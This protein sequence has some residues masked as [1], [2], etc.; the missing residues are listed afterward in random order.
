MLKSLLAVVPLFAVLATVHAVH[1]AADNKA[2]PAAGPLQFTMKDIDGK[3]VDLAQ[4]KGKV[5]MIVNVASK[6]GNTPQYKQL[7]EAYK[8]YGDK[9]F[10]ILGFPANE[11]RQQEPGTNEEIKKFCTSKYNVDFPM[12][13]K[14]VVK[15]DGQAPLYQYL[16]SKQT[17][18]K[19]AGDI[20]WNFEK[21]LVGRDGQVAARFTPKTKPDAPEVTKAIE[22][23]L[24]K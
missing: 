8:K 23:E 10:V 6:C 11:F 9:G 14:I 2:K 12:F 4:Y 17:N 22:T 15:G 16:T 24:A 21:F 1:A 19:F 20:T 3:D 5:V 13:S 18:P 7:E